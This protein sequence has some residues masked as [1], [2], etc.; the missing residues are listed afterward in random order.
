[1]ENNLKFL[2]NLHVLKSPESEKTV[3]MKVSVC[4]SVVAQVVFFL[5]FSLGWKKNALTHAVRNST[6]ALT[7][8]L[9]APLLSRQTMI[10]EPR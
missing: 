8:K 4:L 10:P 3:F 9:K 6:E 7:T 5:F 2:S 1:M